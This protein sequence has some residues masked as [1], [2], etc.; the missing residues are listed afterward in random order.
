VTDP[1]VVAHDGVIVV[2]GA[3]VPLLYR[4]V[5]AL[6]IRHRR[7][8]VASP[9][10]LHELRTVLYRAT[11]MSPPRH[12]VSHVY[13]SSSCCGCQGECDWLSVGEVSSLLGVSRRQVQR[14][15]AESS[16]RGG[17]DAIVGRTWALRRAPALALAERRDRDRTD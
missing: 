13:E 15:A 8:G 16:R 2:S 1:P 17:L 6:A 9:A 14:M 3:A 12:K 5:L 7:D 4:A 11:T 10:L